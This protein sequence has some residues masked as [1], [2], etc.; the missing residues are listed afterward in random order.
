MSPEPKCCPECGSDLNAPNAATF[1]RHHKRPRMMMVGGVMICLGVLLPIAAAF[2]LTQFRGGSTGNPNRSTAAILAGLPGTLNTPWDWNELDNRLRAGKLSRQEVDQ[3]ITILT[4]D[5]TQQRAAGKPQSPLPWSGTFLERAMSLNQV[6]S[7]KLAA[8]CQAFYGPGPE[9]TLSSIVRAGQPLKFEANCNG[10]PWTLAQTRLVWVLTRVSGEDGSALRLRR[11]SDLPAASKPD[12]FSGRA[13]DYWGDALA[14][15]ALSPGE[16]ELSFILDVGAVPSSATLRGLDGKPGTADKWPTPVAT[17]QTVIKK[18]IRVVGKD[19]PVIALVTDPA[20][21]PFRS[22][23]LSISEAV[24]R[25]ASRGSQL[26]LK[27][28]DFPVPTVPLS[29]QVTLVAGSQRIAYGSYLTAAIGRSSTG[30]ITDQ[31]TIPSLPADVTTVDLI[32]TPDPKNAER[33]IGIDRIWGRPFEIKNIPLLRYDLTP[34]ESS[35]T[36]P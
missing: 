27:W 11:E 15:H 10:V 17:W 14:D 3:A 12:Q 2:V 32:C 22:N 6:A 21:D 28:K 24:V 20:L 29:Y 34:A 18:N 26:V 33:I 9:I 35:T 36:K 25:P 8:L 30:S 13:H 4:A 16:H 5:L 19:E 7:P 1:G 31:A 23:A